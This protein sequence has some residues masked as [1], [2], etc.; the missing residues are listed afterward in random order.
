M[1]F[2]QFHYPFSMK[3]EEFMT[4]FPGDFIAEGIDQTR[5]WFYTLNVIGT[6]VMNS[7]PFKNLVCNGI[8]LASDGKKMSKRLK[9][10]PDPI[11]ITN[12]YG[13]D[14][15]RLYLAN[16]P[17]VRAETLKFS[18]KGV[19]GIVKNVFL[20]W[21]NVYRFLVQNIQRW[22]KEHDK[23][24]IFDEN[25]KTNTRNAD[26]N[27]MDKWIVAE[28][29]KLIKYFRTEMSAYRLYTVVP[30][31]LKFLRDLTNWYVR[32]N[33]TRIKGETSEADRLAA[34]NTLFEVTMNITIL[35][36][37][38]TP[39]ITDFFYL[40]LKNGIDKNSKLHEDTVHYLQIP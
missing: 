36:S 34:L 19:E 7:N 9:N 17:I 35:M 30:E 1:P 5:G 40:N 13:A 18:E 24:F 3:E 33:R 39:F 23:N 27:I 15:C 32:L 38:F 4:R 10:Y 21:F 2:A 8:C 6:A 28:A 22:E 37:P 29:Q 16:S 11:D 31:L 20:P 25:A 12:S 26:T 14:A